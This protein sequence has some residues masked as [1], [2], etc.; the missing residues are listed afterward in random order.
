MMMSG[1]LAL[2]EVATIDE[3][4][5]MKADCFRHNNLQADDLEQSYIKKMKSK[6]SSEAFPLPSTIRL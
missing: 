6:H 4:P 5:N 2:N 1:K 3:D